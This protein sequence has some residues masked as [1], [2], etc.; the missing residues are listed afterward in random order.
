MESI[1]SYS[2]SFYTVNLVA[3]VTR[4]N[5]GF[6][7]FLPLDWDNRFSFLLNVIKREYAG[8]GREVYVC[9]GIICE[10]VSLQLSE[11][12]SLNLNLNWES[13]ILNFLGS[14]YL[15]MKILFKNKAT[16]YLFW[17]KLEIM[18]RTLRQMSCKSFRPYWLP[19]EPWE[20]LQW[21][22]ARNN[23]TGHEIWVIPWAPKRT[24]AM[25]FGFC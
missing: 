2:Q 17:K 13:E 18:S 6:S 7:T 24:C 15:V 16:Q 25:P 1:F 21:S 23:Q 14:C 9:W 4:R 20:G 3:N 19:L 11:R 12:L 22:S 5:L 8:K 10:S